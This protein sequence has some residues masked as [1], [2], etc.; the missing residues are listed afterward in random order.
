MT[1]VSAPGPIE[2][3]QLEVAVSVEARYA[4]EP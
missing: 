3:G 1:T 4:I 2:S